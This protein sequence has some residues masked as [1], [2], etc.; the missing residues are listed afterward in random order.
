MCARVGKKLFKGMKLSMPRCMLDT[1]EAINWV[2]K[3]PRN[4]V[5]KT[6]TLKKLFTKLKKNNLAD[7]QMIKK[8][9]GQS[10]H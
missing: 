7:P 2:E 1:S 4:G 5:K 3:W 6:N 8:Y 10:N 9:Y